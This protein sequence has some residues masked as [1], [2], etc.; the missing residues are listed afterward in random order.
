MPRRNDTLDENLLDLMG[1]LYR[2]LSAEFVGPNSVNSLTVGQL[3]A[4]KGMSSAA[5]P[6]A[7]V[8]QLMGV[9]PATATIMV[10]KLVE[11]G[12]A[13]RQSDASNLRTVLVSATPAGRSLW[14]KVH[15]RAMRRAASL[16]GHLDA[17]ER[18]AL[19]RTLRR[20][21]EVCEVKVSG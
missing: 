7:A 13:E 9:K 10:G 4:L 5:L 6:M 17:A 12:L 1:R 15:K 21:I 11:R 2:F 19:D 18:A 20:L 3:R 14:K 16:T 8:A